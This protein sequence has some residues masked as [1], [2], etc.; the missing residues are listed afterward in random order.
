MEGDNK[1][2]D[3]DVSLLLS[4]CEEISV[5]PLSSSLDTM[6][7]FQERKRRHYKSKYEHRRRKYI[8]N[9]KANNKYKK[10]CTHHRN[11][12][13]QKQQ[14]SDHRNR[15][16]TVT[17]QTITQE[18]H[19]QKANFKCIINLNTTVCDH[20]HR[21]SINV[22]KSRNSKNQQRPVPQCQKPLCRSSRPSQ[23]KFCMHSKESNNKV[24]LENSSLKLK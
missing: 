1:N 16:E 23:T 5:N 19:V 24:S 17:K 12:C 2:S 14:S 22:E 13:E 20:D 15:L 7:S 3:K 21:S 6:S 8:G 9:S 18:I 10:H 4:D 11:K